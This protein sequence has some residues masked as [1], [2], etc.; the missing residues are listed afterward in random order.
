MTFVHRLDD[1]S[2]YKSKHVVANRK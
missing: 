2:S 1:D